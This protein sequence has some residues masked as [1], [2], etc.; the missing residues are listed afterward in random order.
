MRGA[1]QQVVVAQR[2]YSVEFLGKGSWIYLEPMP[3][4][5]QRLDPIPYLWQNI[6]RGLMEEQ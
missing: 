4:P 3:D 5:Y 1:K 2:P 6:L